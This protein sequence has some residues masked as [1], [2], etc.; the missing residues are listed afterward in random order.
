MNA[1]RPERSLGIGIVLSALAAALLIGF[2]EKA[3]PGIRDGSCLGGLVHGR[4]A[5]ALCYSDIVPLYGT[6]GLQS[7]RLPYLQA[8]SP[9]LE[10]QCDEYPPLTMYTMWLAALV[11]TGYRTFFYANAVFLSIAAVATAWCLYVLA[12]RRALYFALAPTLVLYAYFNW[13]LVAVALATAATL[14]FL[15]RR[16][17]LSGMLLGLGAAAKLY[18]G[19]LLIPFIIQRFREREVHRATLLGS[20][21]IGAWLAVNLPFMILAPRGW[22]TF[23][24]FNGSRPL[25]VDS[26]WFIGCRAM[27]PSSGGQCLSPGLANVLAVAL[28]ASLGATVWLIKTRRDRDFPR[29]TFGFP[30]VVLF[31]LT[32]KVY[33]PQFSLWLLP[34]FAVALPGVGRLSSLRLFLVFGAAECG[35]FV[36]ELLWFS[37]QSGGTG[38][39]QWALAAAILAR[40]AIL[41]ACLV[42]WILRPAPTL[43]RM[44]RVAEHDVSVTR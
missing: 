18:P 38:P 34:W 10:G 28:V 32:S 44:Q 7:G 16:D 33:S 23:F 21:S 26:L 41:V 19:L 27:R 43:P 24:R 25:N 15:L 6:E 12:R 9:P 31:L 36:T 2:L 40:D 30:L 4:Q 37:A 8:C 20:A 14:A 22:S 11:A 42:A 35:L 13:D 39:P 3:E 17:G 5:D 29:W 1:V